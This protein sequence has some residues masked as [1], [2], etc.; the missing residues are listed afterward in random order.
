MS[1]PSREPAPGGVGV[2]TGMRRRGGAARPA[3]AAAA[4]ALLA[5]SASA[6]LACGGA[7][8]IGIG[9]GTRWLL[10]EVPEFVQLGAERW[11]LTKAFVRGRV[12]VDCPDSVRPLRAPVVFPPRPRGPG[13]RADAPAPSR[14]A[15]SF[16]VFLAPTKVEVEESAGVNRYEMCAWAPTLRADGEI[17]S[18]CV[19]EV[20]PYSN[21]HVMLRRTDYQM[22]ERKCSL[23]HEYASPGWIPAYVLA[24]AAIFFAAPSLSRNGLFRSAAVVFIFAAVA[25]V[26]LLFFLYKT[27]TSPGAMWKLLALSLFPIAGTYLFGSYWPML[28]RLDAQSLLLV[29]CIVFGVCGMI[30]SFLYEGS[31]A[32]PNVGKMLRLFLWISGLGLV[33]VGVQSEP[34]F[35]A[36]LAALLA[37]AVVWQTEYLPGVRSSINGAAGGALVALVPWIG[38]GRAAAAAALAAPREADEGVSGP[39]TPL[40]PTSPGSDPRGA[41]MTRSPMTA[42]S[43]GEDAAATAETAATP[44]RSMNFSSPLVPEMLDDAQLSPVVKEGKIVN[45]VTK[46]KIMIHGSTYHK[47]IRSGYSPDFTTG[48]LSPPRSPMM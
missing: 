20:N 27:A 33:F 30:I 18:R 35:N 16:S 9:I 31:L 6:A 43:N 38:S 7:G 29:Y 42:C 26:F 32:N 15:Q 8:G 39:K 21:F 4:V 17:G 44:K 28:S 19:R 48:L 22:A 13:A 34:V 47:L 37:G 14:P 23:S 11:D 41:N 46:R 36:L 1:P 3:A 24:G 2:G 45:A 40:L 12:I 5:A 10:P 25:H